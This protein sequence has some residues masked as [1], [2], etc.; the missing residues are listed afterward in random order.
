[1]AVASDTV[2]EAHTALLKAR[3]FYNQFTDKSLDLAG[4]YYRESL[5]HDPD[6]APAY[7]GL[8]DLAWAYTALSDFDEAF[9]W[10]RKGMDERDYSV[11]SLNAH[12]NLAPFRGD[13][14]FKE[15]VK[16]MGLGD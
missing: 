3:Y 15:L 16:E 8:S 4:Q 5:R 2:P 9:R 13:P 12:P 11:V 10:I 1:M 14:R 7:A 6:Y